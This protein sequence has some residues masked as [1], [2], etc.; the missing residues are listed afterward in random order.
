MAL[1]GNKPIDEVHKSATDTLTEMIAEEAAAETAP[2]Q[3]AK[4]LSVED[5]LARIERYLVAQGAPF[6]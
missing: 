3:P 6:E 1:R 4:Q 5:R 2:Q